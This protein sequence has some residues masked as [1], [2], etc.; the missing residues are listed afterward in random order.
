M[1]AVPSSVSGSTDFLVQSLKLQCARLLIIYRS[2][3]KAQIWSG[4]V[5]S[6][7]LRS[8]GRVIERGSQRVIQGKVVCRFQRVRVIA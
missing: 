8:A 7:N 6:T 5:S 1:R 2:L 4:K 3:T